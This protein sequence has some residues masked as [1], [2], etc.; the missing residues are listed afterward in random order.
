MIRHSSSFLFSIVFHIALFFLLLFI[1]N[2]YVK[3]KDIVCEQRVCMKL[4]NMKSEKEVK[5]AQKLQKKIEKKEKVEEKKVKKII[6]KKE[7]IKKQKIQKKILKK[8]E[9]KKVKIEKKEIKKVKITSEEKIITKPKIK[10]KQ[11]VYVVKEVK[12]QKPV[13]AIK[14]DLTKDYLKEHLAK[15]QELLKENLYYPRRARK[16][17]IIGEVMVKFTINT[18]GEVY[19]IKILNSKKEILAKAAIRTIENLSGKFP[20]PTENLTLKVPIV[21]FLE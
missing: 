16:K 11:E 6:K 15:I 19:N 8:I 12:I 18:N 4:C 20:K 10:K 13:V 9:P 5:V 17:G 1:Y 21:Y 3:K 7:P 14:Q 2:N